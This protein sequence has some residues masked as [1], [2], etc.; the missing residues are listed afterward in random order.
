MSECV[1]YCYHGN[2]IIFLINMIDRE[3]FRHNI[4]MQIRYIP[5]KTIYICV[6]LHGGVLKWDDVGDA[7][8]P[9]TLRIIF[10]L[11]NIRYTRNITI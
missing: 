2:N 8:P 11:S 4:Y 3:Y 10:Y 9:R 6:Y 1:S 5:K 7:S